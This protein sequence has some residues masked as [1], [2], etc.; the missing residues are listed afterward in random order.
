MVRIRL[1]RKGR[2]HQPVYDIVA[3]DG[4]GRRDG[5]YLERL[6]YFDPNIQPSKIVLNPERALYWLGVGAQP[7]ETVKMLL[8]YDGVLLRKHLAHKGVPAETIEAE[9]EKHKKIVAERYSRRKDLRKKRK[10]NKA[11]AEAAAAEAPAAEAA[12]EATAE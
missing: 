10:I 2:I 6:G 11:K 12:P 5:G 4:R 7:T 8:S 3:V 1:R 9:V